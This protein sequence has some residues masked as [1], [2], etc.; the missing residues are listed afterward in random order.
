MLGQKRAVIV[1]TVVAAVGTTAAAVVAA[2]ATTAVGKNGDGSYDDAACSN[3]CSGEVMPCPPAT[4]AQLA[5]SFSCEQAFQRGIAATLLLL[6]CL[7]A[8]VHFH[9]SFFKSQN[10]R[11]WYLKVNLDVEDTIAV[12]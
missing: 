1:G 2:S 12:Q 5:R 7:N 4:V 10:L 8:I 9:D 6:L 11:P 3:R